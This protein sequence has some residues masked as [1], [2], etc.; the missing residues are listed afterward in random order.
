MRSQNALRGRQRIHGRDT[1]RIPKWIV[2]PLETT[3]IELGIILRWE[4]DGG[5][6]IET[7][8]T[9]SSAGSGSNGSRKHGSIP[10]EPDDGY[11]HTRD[12]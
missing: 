4:D 3:G 11:G 10:K 6:I 7:A 5:R 2:P 9:V 12:R 8:G 1:D